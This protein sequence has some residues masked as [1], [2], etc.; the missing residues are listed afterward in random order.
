M[1][2]WWRFTSGIYLVAAVCPLLWAPVSRVDLFNPVHQWH[3]LV[4]TVSFVCVVFFSSVLQEER[5]R[6]DRKKRWWGWRWR[7]RMKLQTK[8]R[9]R[10]QRNKEKQGNWKKKEIKQRRRRKR[11]R[12]KIGWLLFVL[13][14]YINALSTASHLLVQSRVLQN[15]KYSW[16]DWTQ[17]SAIHNNYWHIKTEFAPV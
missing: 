14:V 13:G 8:R 15:V 3:L 2:P 4:L 7:K 16:Q 10:R 12:T 9:R 6:K 11:K 17:L 1:S 5:K